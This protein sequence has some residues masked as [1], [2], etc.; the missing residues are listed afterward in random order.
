MPA[1]PAGAVVFP[2]IPAPAPSGPQV[3]RTP[4]KTGGELMAGR[5]K[6]V[7]R[8]KWPGWGQLFPSR[9]PPPHFPSVTPTASRTQPEPHTTGTASPELQDRSVLRS[10]CPSCSFLPRG[11]CAWCSAIWNAFLSFPCLAVSSSSSW[12]WFGAPFSS[13][14][15][16]QTPPTSGWARHLLGLLHRSP[17]LFGGLRSCFP[18]TW[19]THAGEAGSGLLTQYP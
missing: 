19:A 1:G 18:P 7:F 17:G 15:P 16:A 13:G 2:R 3:C 8:W 10:A 11:L 6:R 12:S 9:P 5:G 4:R 14:E